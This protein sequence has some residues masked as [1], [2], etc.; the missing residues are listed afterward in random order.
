MS[1][2]I[3]LEVNLQTIAPDAT[4]QGRHPAMLEDFGAIGYKLDHQATAAQI[5]TI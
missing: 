2:G 5:E 4:Q 1:L 3:Y